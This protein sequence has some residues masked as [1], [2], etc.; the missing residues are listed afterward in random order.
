MV[1]SRCSAE[2]RSVADCLSLPGLLLGRAPPVR[3]SGFKYALLHRTSVS[4]V[5]CSVVEPAY[6]PI[7]HPYGCTQYWDLKCLFTPCLLLVA[8][9]HTVLGVVS[10]DW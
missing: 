7:W 10:P 4:A 9:Q 5:Y 8:V 3:T 6:G 1:L 2:W